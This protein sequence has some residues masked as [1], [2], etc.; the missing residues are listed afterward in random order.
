[1]EPRGD[2][3]QVKGEGLKVLLTLVEG[4]G[5]PLDGNRYIMCVSA[6]FVI[7]CGFA[8]QDNAGYKKAMQN[9]L[10]GYSIH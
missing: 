1:M 2:I 8:S 4:A 10:G 3:L 9:N 5:R 7:A 6:L